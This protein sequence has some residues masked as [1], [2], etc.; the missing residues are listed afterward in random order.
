MCCL[1]RTT[2]ASTRHAPDKTAEEMRRSRIQTFARRQLQVSGSFRDAVG[3]HHYFNGSQGLAVRS[4]DVKENRCG[5]IRKVARKE[6]ETEVKLY[7]ETDKKKISAARPDF[8]K[9][10]NEK[11]RSEREKTLNV[12]DGPGQVSAVICADLC[13]QL[14]SAALGP[15]LRPLACRTCMFK[16]ESAYGGSHY[17]KEDARKQEV[18]RKQQLRNRY[19]VQ[20]ARQDPRSLFMIGWSKRAQYVILTLAGK[21]R[22]AIANAERSLSRR[23]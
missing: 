3:R 15:A 8:C 19:S 18:T 13:S 7:S 11:L 14:S 23:R 12:F 5:T 16:R 4:E 10:P 2:R 6:R 22:D 21:P 1:R 17:E 20:A 9:R